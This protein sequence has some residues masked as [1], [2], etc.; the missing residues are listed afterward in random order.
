[1]TIENQ[2]R[3]ALNKIAKTVDDLESTLEKLKGEDNKVKGWYEQK[4]AVHEIKKILS[5]A[6]SYDEFD[7]AEYLAFMGEYNSYMFPGEYNQTIY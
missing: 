3:T 5:E 6:T 7:S 1:M 4:K 2:E